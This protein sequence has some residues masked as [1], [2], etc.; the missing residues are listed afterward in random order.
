MPEISE[1]RLARFEAIEAAGETAKSHWGSSGGAEAMV[2]L[3]EALKPV[4]V[5]LVSD[6]EIER[7]WGYVAMGNDD[8]TA[9]RRRVGALYLRKMLCDLED[10]APGHV[11]VAPGWINARMEKRWLEEET[12]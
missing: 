3:G 7:V 4:K 10:N 8:L 6:E 12:S 2:A 1:E 5:P 11:S 9:A